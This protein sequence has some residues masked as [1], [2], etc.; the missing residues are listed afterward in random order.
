MSFLS[1]CVFFFSAVYLY[2]AEKKSEGVIREIRFSGLIYTKGYV[3]RRELY[4]R[5]G[6]K[7]NPEMWI[8]E[9]N[10]L[11]GLDLFTGVSLKV[12]EEEDG[13]VLNYIFTELFRFIVFPSVKRTDLDGWLAGPAVA[14]LN[15]FGTDTRLEAY[16][17]TTAADPFATNELLLEMSSPW[18]L[19]LPME[20]VIGFMKTDSY[21]SLKEFE[22]NSFNGTVNFYYRMFPFLRVICNAEILSVEVDSR[23]SRF[24]PDGIERESFF[25]SS[26]YD[27]VP[28]AGIGLALDTR[29][30]RLNPHRGM[31]QELRISQSGGFIGGDGNF[32]EYLF[33]LRGW[34]AFFKR[35]IFHGSFLGQYRPGE[36]GVYDYYHAGGTNSLRTYSPEPGIFGQHEAIFTLEYRYEIIGR[37]AFSFLDFNFYLG[38]QAVAGTD[39]VWLWKKEYAF[40]D[41][42]YY[43]GYYAG[44]HILAPGFDRLRIEGGFHDPDLKDWSLKFG[45][46]IGLWEKSEVQRWRKR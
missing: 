43:G 30:R 11:E 23:N 12:I 41:A 44:I 13:I 4:H 7:Y 36:I 17:R 6:G 2:S 31:Y 25:S 38:L 14:Y 34:L 19:S 21:N 24:S 33:D 20:Y 9:K 22:E 27:V 10:A 40:R 45:F 16:A 37:Y 1:A 46:S 5:E 29:D 3:V 8:K 15:L 18:L 39:Q 35:H 26:G 28:K 32:T 42:D